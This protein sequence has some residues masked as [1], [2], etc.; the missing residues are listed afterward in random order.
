MK[1]ETPLTKAT[2]IKRYKRFLADIQL[3]NN[4]TKTIFCP[5]TGSMRECAIPGQ[6]VWFSTVDNPKRK[7]QDTWELYQNPAGEMIGINTH[8]ANAL[9]AEALRHG[10]ITE[11]AEYD[12]FSQEYRLN[13]KTRLDFL[14]HGAKP[15]YLE[16]KSVTLSLEPGQG[17]FPDA[18]TLRGQKHLRELIELKQQGANC[19]L[20]FC[21]QHTGIRAVAAAMAID[22]EYGKLLQQAAE[23]GVDI[24]AY[25]CSIS[26]QEISINQE[27]VVN[28]EN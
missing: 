6:P 9:V 18:K 27:V 2:L 16:V 22:S 20:L 11:L 13:P 3:P 17:L 5:N 15:Y 8:R 7:Y 12:D 28:L 21:V 24:M 1:Y 25:G 26:A 23:M 14:L 4:E 19:G 10:R